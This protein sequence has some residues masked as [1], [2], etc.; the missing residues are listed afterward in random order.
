MAARWLERISAQSVFVLIHAVLN[1]GV[2][3]VDEI[4]FIQARHCVR[5]I[6][7][8]A[9]VV[10]HLACKHKALDGLVGHLA[11]EHETIA[12]GLAL[13]EIAAIIGRNGSSDAFGIKQLVPVVVAACP[14]NSAIRSDI[15][16]HIEVAAPVVDS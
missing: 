8:V 4:A 10:A 13:V 16:G 2:P 5:V 6:H 3:I 9:L 14:V 1:I 7:R 12:L 11:I 15:V